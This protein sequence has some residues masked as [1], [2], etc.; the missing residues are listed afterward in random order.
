MNATTRP[1]YSPG[2]RRLHW[3]MAVLIA[4]AYLLIEQRGIFYAKFVIK[5]TKLIDV[6]IGHRFALCP[7]ARLN[8]PFEG[9]MGFG[10]FAHLSDR[11]GACNPAS[12]DSLLDSEA[13]GVW[14]QP[15]KCQD[16]LRLAVGVRNA[17]GQGR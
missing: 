2:L 12:D 17:D 8:E 1:R 14:P 4:L 7:L 3:L 10:V 9:L 16:C 5:N 15:F 11:L 6:F 13:G